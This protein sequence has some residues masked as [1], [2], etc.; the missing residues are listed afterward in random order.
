MVVGQWLKD[1][2]ASVFYSIANLKHVS[3]RG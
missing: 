1:G 3:R 2:D